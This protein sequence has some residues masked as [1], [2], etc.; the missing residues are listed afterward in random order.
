MNGFI[1]IP[2]ADDWPAILDLARASAPWDDEDRIL[3]WYRFRQEA[4]RQG[5]TR[6]EYVAVDLGSGLVTG[7]A[8]AEASDEPGAYRLF[9]VTR[10]ERLDTVGNALYDRLAAAVSLLDAQTAWVREDAAD[11][12]IAFFAARGFGDPQRF[13]MPHGRDG[14]AM[15]LRWQKGL[16]VEGS[17]GS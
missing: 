17:Q 5:R 2:T 16:K 13:S 6:R 12:L 11:P 4:A 8:L 3:G 9:V 1:R 14:I 15:R 10:H 7:Y